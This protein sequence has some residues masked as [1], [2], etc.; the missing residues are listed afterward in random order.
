MAMWLFT[1]AILAG[2]P[3]K[4]FNHGRMRRDF[5]F[6]DDI[7]SG[8]VAVAD[9]P[10]SRTAD[11]VSHRVY[12]I[13]HNRP[14]DLLHMI[15]VLEKAVGRPAEKIML[16]MQPGDVPQ[17]YADIDAI[18]RDHGFEPSTPIET[19][20]SAFRRLVQA[21]S[22]PRTVTSS[23]RPPRPAAHR[24]LESRP[25]AATFRHHAWGAPSEYIVPD[26]DHRHDCPRRRRAAGRARP[27]PGSGPEPGA[28]EP[29]LLER[30]RL[31]RQSADWRTVETLAA[32]Y[33]EGKP[34]IARSPSCGRGRASP[35][36]LACG[37]DG[38]V[39]R[40]GSAPRTRGRRSTS[41]PAR[42]SARAT[43]SRRLGRAS[44]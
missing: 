31:A 12:N 15:A 27:R 43:S 42:S 5:T 34:R 8:V 14:D 39:A 21:L 44:G 3:I 40:R 7:V 13:G 25:L 17:T 23:S 30:I 33:L 20:I 18:R 37:G 26:H 24:P 35:Q 9:S 41:S 10:P 19:G 22:R 11:G 38:V 36:G 1:R 32:A 16:P 4:V 2:E 28:P 29:Q 6:V